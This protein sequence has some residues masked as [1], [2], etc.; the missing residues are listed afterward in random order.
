MQPRACSPAQ[1]QL[2]R[3]SLLD[4]LPEPWNRQLFVCSLISSTRCTLMEGACL[5]DSPLPDLIDKALNWPDWMLPCL[6]PDLVT[7]FLLDVVCKPCALSSRS[8]CCV[9]SRFSW[10]I[11]FHFQKMNA[12][13]KIS[14]AIDKCYIQ[15]PSISS[16][17][18][19]ST[20]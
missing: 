11:T 2:N 7:D 14:C 3:D 15:A 17:P 19:S 10:N 5:P 1:L 20:Q 4:W 6:E 13:V 18:T 8:G 12:V 9:R 16:T